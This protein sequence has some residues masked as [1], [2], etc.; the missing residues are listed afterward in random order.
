MHSRVLQGS[1]LSWI[2][3]VCQ[4]HGGAEREQGI[5]HL[6]SEFLGSLISGQ[7]FLFLLPLKAST[8][9]SVPGIGRAWE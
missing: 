3:D 7:S 9:R 4:Q 2:G 5:C 1:V 6:W 8:R